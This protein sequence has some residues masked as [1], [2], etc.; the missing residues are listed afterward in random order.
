MDKNTV[1]EGSSDWSF[2]WIQE[3]MTARMKYQWNEI[4]NLTWGPD[5]VKREKGSAYKYHN[6]L[7]LG[8]RLMGQFS[9][10]VKNLTGAFPSVP[11]ADFTKYGYWVL[12]KQVADEI[13]AHML[14]N[15]IAPN[16]MLL[17]G[18]SQ[19]G[20]R[21]A[22]ISMYWKKKHGI[23]VKTLTLGRTGPG[24][25]TRL[26]HSHANMLDDVDPTVPHPQITDYA[27]PLDP[28]GSAFGVDVGRSCYYFKGASITDDPGYKSC[29]QIWGWSAPKLFWADQAPLT[30][31]SS[32]M[33]TLKYDFKACRY[34]VHWA[35]ITVWLL[36]QPGVI[37]EDGSTAFCVDNTAI[38]LDDPDQVCPTGMCKGKCAASFNGMIFGFFLLFFISFFLVILGFVVLLRL[39][40]GKAFTDR[41]CCCFNRCMCCFRCQQQQQAGENLPLQAE[42]H[43][44]GVEEVEVG[45]GVLS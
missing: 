5:N 31:L 11:E 29:Q 35:E 6:Y 20:S 34:A 40:F 24:C 36:E 16:R 8:S 7:R 26:L 15:A 43:P 32:E 1:H 9:T 25:F 23:S 13:Y 38:P 45:Q 3:R 14:D 42:K 17:S 30:I 44:K 2:D 28:L 21:A 18:H 12:T 37:H 27:H 19:G 39:I 33:G 22:L 10:L 41:F 4:L